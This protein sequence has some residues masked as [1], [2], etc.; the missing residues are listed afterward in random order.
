VK[1]DGGTRLFGFCN[2]P[3]AIE[4]RLRSL[5]AAFLFLIYIL[6]L[7]GQSLPRQ[8]AKAQGQASMKGKW[9]MLTNS[10]NTTNARA[11]KITVKEGRKGIEFYAFNFQHGK[12]LHIGTLIGRTYEKTAPILQKPEPSFSLPQSELGAAIEQGAEFIRFIAR[13]AIG[14]YAISVTDFQLFAQPYY[15]QAY[16]P[17][18]RVSLGNFS[19]TSKVSKRNAHI[20][21]PA[22]EQAGPLIKQEKQL[23]LFR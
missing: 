20:D 10:N 18:M 16:G 21:N 2:E 19:H 12:P 22:I 14:T 6:P 3:R 5:R 23:G 4:K 13:G 17:Q 7:I 15:N 8:G 11:G 9:N 1:E